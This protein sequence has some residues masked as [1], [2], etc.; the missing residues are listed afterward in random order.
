[1]LKITKEK[2]ERMEKY[3]GW[4]DNLDI[5]VFDIET[6]STIPNKDYGRLI[7]ISAVKLN[8]NNYEVIDRFDELI[9]PEMRISN[10]TQNLTGI[11]QD[12]LKGKR[13]YPE[14]V[15]DFIDFCS[16]DVVI[17]G[18][19]ISTFDI[20]FVNYFA[21][22]IGLSFNPERVVDT[23]FMSKNTDV[24]EKCAKHKLEYLAN[25][26]GIDDPSHHRAMND[27][28]VNVDVLNILHQKAK[29]Q[30]FKPVFDK[31]ELLSSKT[32]ENNCT[33]KE[34]KT[35]EI[36]YADVEVRSIN[37]WTKTI[38]DKTYRRLY[39]K[40][41]ANEIYLDAFYD[42]D[43]ER[44]QVKANEKY[45]FLINWENVQRDIARLRNFRNADM[46]L[47]FENYV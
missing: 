41:F 19:N 37:L 14:V 47:E 45:D 38:K 40:L 29:S 31:N 4:L 36:K 20:R 33:S 26:Y 32:K 35:T 39:V 34:N 21:N 18:H 9:D 1:M 15:K 24:K 28:I 27:V 10:T 12:M 23:L 7:E 16:G 30:G 3:I 5:I 25:Y 11:T 17:A 8:H 13:K 2:K 22:I 42:F 43:L 46:V 6:T 44:W